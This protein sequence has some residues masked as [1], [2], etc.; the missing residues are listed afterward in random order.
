MTPREK[1][2]ILEKKKNK[3]IE[4]EVARF[5]TGDPILDCIFSNNETAPKG[6]P[7]G[8]YVWLWG[9]SKA[10][11]SAL[12]IEAIYNMLKH[13]GK[14]N[15]DYI[16]YDVEEAYSFDSE[17]R[18]GFTI[19]DGK[20]I[21]F[22]KT[23]EEWQVMLEQFVEGK[24]PKR[25]KIMILD[26]SDA[27]T[28]SEELARKDDRVKSFKKTGNTGVQK[29]YGMEKA[30]KIGEVLRTC[31]STI[32]ENNI[33][34]FIISQERANVN[35]GLFEKK[36]IVSGGKAP[37]FFSSIQMELKQVE[38][39][40]DKWRTY[41]GCVQ[42]HAQ[43]T[44]TPFEGRRVF[45]NVDWD[46]GYDS[47]SSGID[48]LYDLKDEYGKLE[49]AKAESLKWPE[50]FVVEDTEVESVT[51]KEVKDFAL[52]LELKDQMKENGKKFTIKNIKEYISEDPKLREQFVT[53]FGVMARQDMV[54]WI[55]DD[56]SGAREDE[57]MKRVHL[58]FYEIERRSK[59]NR[60]KRKSL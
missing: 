32:A 41:G 14:A 49:T 26:S 46:Q 23:V 57:L 55:E 31:T 11:K 38:A 1:E 17:S 60:K 28:V 22:P 25:P 24:D 56:E 13:Y 15:V 47:I 6:Y 29:T 3:K 20:H 16:W 2:A 52:G 30:K 50:K 12:C 34:C 5:P 48:F 19:N 51:D 54:N 45:V 33:I 37:G 58:K 4:K 53:K 40:G 7:L 39:F 8:K 43:K 35:A 18:M 21:R 27:L 36:T 42:I 9:P 59:P 44:R 10:G